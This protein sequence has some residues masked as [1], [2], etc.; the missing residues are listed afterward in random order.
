MSDILMIILSIFDVIIMALG[1]DY[2]CKGKFRDEAP[3]IFLLGWLFFQPMFWMFFVI[4]GERYN[5]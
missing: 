2:F 3:A 1:L 5:V 4:I